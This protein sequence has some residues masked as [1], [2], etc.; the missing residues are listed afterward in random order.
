MRIVGRRG[1]L[2]PASSFDV[3]EAE[4]KCQHAQIWSP[5]RTQPAAKRPKVFDRCLVMQLTVRPNVSKV[6][7]D[8]INWSR[9]PW[10]VRFAGSVLEWAECLELTLIG[11]G[12]QSLDV[13]A[14]EEILV[15]AGYPR[16][17]SKRM[18][19]V[20]GPITSYGCIVPRKIHD[21]DSACR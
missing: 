10:W 9:A 13:C 11:P 19:F 7:C 17:S 1:K 14:I 16:F 15:P 18:R 5:A 4:R 3:H 20:R 8:L 2:N 12:I 21:L 6:S